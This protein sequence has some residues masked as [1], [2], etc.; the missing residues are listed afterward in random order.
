M[1][2]PRPARGPA[3]T[4]VLR[5]APVALLGLLLLALTRTAGLGISDPD[6]LWHVLA[7]DHLRETGQFARNDG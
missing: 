6:T 3:P 4:G 1:P 5:W 2:D 7:G